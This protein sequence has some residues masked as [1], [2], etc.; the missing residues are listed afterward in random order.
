M[1]KINRNSNI[2]PFDN[3][4]LQSR[5]AITIING[6][7]RWLEDNQIVEFVNPHYLGSNAEFSIKNCSG[8]KIWFSQLSSYGVKEDDFE[9]PLLDEIIFNGQSMCHIA[10]EF[11]SASDFWDA[12]KG[13][14]FKVNVIGSGYCLN[15]NSEL[16]KNLRMSAS[17]DS[18]SNKNVDRSVFN[19]IRNAV[20]NGNNPSVYG[21]LKSKKAYRLSEI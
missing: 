8:Q 5:D 19:Y 7:I 17:R 20:R 21:T 6:E 1:N 10:E 16:V 3:I 15:K 11:K 14:R 2:N 9:T 18:A 13:K 12:V 4:V